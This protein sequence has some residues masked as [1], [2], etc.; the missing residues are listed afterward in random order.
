MKKQ[1]AKQETTKQKKQQKQPINLISIKDQWKKPTKSNLTFIDL[2]SG[3]GGITKGF[4]L[5]GLK[6]IAGFDLNRDAV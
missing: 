3:C 2:F 5:A 1:Q 6:P 4:E